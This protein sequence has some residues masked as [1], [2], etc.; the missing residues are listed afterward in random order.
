[1][2]TAHERDESERLSFSV[3]FILTGCQQGPL[4]YGNKSLIR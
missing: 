3:Y 4:T 2:V 1:M